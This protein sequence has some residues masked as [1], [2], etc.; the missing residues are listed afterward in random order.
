M[1]A[2]YTDGVTEAFSPA[3]EEF[4]EDRLIKVLQKRRDLPARDLLAAVVEEVQRFSPAEQSDDVT[5]VIARCRH[6]Q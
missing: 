5:L 1:L 3:G 6:P 4:G 2:I